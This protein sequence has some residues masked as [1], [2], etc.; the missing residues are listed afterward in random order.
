MRLFRVTVRHLCMALMKLLPP[1]RCFAFKRLLLRLSGIGVGRNVRVHSKAIFESAFV[2]IGENTWIGAGTRIGGAPDASIQIGRNCDVAPECLLITGSHSIG[3]SDHRAG[4]GYSMPIVIGDGTWL[5]ARVVVLG[6]VRVGR[7]CVIAAGAVV[8]RT[9][10]DNCLV[11]GVP[12]RILRVLSD[13][14]GPEATLGSQV[15]Q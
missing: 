14:T 12:G 11:A 9:T 15:Q 6:G 7:G 1:T 13:E 2:T 5:C 10:P 3:A 4:N 8:H